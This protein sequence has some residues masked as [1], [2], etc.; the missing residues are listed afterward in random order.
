MSEGTK[1]TGCG[2]ADCEA[3]QEVS[4]TTPAMSDVIR[5]RIISAGASYL[6]NDNIS[7]Y[8]SEQEKGLL[9]DEV[10]SK[11]EQVLR[12]LVI[13]VDNCHNTNGTARRV[14]KMWLQELYSGR[15]DPAP[16]VTSFPNVNYD[17]LYIAGPITLRS[18]CAHHQMP[19]FGKVYVGVYPGK[20]VIGLSKFNRIVDWYASRPSI[21]EELT[22][23]I[24]DE[25]ERVTE[26]EGLAV[27]IRANHGCVTMRGVQEACSDMT[28]SV[29]R[30]IF[31]EDHS[32]KQEFITLVGQ[33]Q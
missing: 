24:A 16:P 6:C 2:S 27:I 12:S 15:Y 32:I 30:G 18:S 9:L 29:M 20:K 7:E 5:Q 33:M 19:I 23:Q 3:G 22:I 1:L 26:A 10:S 11:M 25:L 17:E 13:D 21:Q 4:C 31:K 8:V 14:A 28:T